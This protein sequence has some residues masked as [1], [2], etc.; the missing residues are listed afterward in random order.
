M[1][2]EILISALSEQTERQ[3]GEPVKMLTIVEAAEK[4]GLAVHAVRCWVKSGELPAV[5]CGKKYL[6]ADMR[7][8]EFL[9]IGNNQAKPE[10]APQ[11]RIRHILI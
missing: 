9:L 11:G 6:I 2:N 8:H 10:A 7:L 4:Y 1:N 3:T 5:K